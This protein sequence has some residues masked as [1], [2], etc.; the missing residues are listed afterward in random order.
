MTPLDRTEP[1]VCQHEVDVVM[2]EALMFREIA[3]RSPTHEALI[4]DYRNNMP[5]LAAQS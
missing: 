5:R 4:Y 3:F 1:I 2:E